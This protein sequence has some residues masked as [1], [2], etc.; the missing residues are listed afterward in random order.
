MDA[1]AVAAARGAAARVVGVRE[2][3]LTAGLFGG[4][5]AAMPLLGWF[6]GTRLSGVVAGWDHWLAF[7]L[8]AGIGVKMLADARGGETRGVGADPFELRVMVVL[9]IATSVDALAVGVTLPML[10]A[11]LAPSVVTIGITTAL[12]SATGV[13]AGA[14]L[15][16]R[17][18]PPLE[19]AGGVLLV[20]IGLKILIDHTTGP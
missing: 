3:V 7:V 10:G 2:V 6:A 1:T 14:R 11:P 17:L 4:F 13:M 8:L 9:A 5:Q 19:I 15:G 16:A 12:L 18:G 20:G